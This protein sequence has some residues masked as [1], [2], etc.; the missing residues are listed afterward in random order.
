MLQGGNILCVAVSAVAGK[1]LGAGFGAGGFL[2]YL[3]GIVV[4]MLGRLCLLN[5]FHRFRRN[6]RSG[7]FLVI[8]A[9]CHGQEHAYRQ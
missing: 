9:S 7:T 3:F 1:G 2:G 4:G 8:T 6:R 5:R